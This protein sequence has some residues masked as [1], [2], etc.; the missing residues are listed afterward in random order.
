MNLA[1]ENFGRI[2]PKHVIALISLLTRLRDAFDGD[3]DSALIMAVI[4]SA[5]LPRLS[6]PSDLTYSELIQHGGSSV[7]TKAPL[8]TNS[9]SAITGIPRETVRRKLDSMVK[10]RLIRKD[11][12]GH[13]EM[14]SFGVRKLRP[15]TEMSLEY[16][17][18]I[19]NVIE[20]TRVSQ[21]IA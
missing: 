9:I 21:R 13:W 12:N 3:L 17:S 20:A 19:A 1:T 16:L 2:W 6:V 18:D 14:Q 15:M 5:V 11:K 7:T 8:N 4:G 10:R